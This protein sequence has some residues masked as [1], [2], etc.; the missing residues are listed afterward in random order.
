MTEFR[1][2][3][4]RKKLT[5]VSWV[6][7]MCLSTIGLC[8]NAI[9]IYIKFSMKP[10]NMPQ[11]F[12]NSLMYFVGPFFIVMTIICGYFTYRMIYKRKNSAIVEFIVG[13]N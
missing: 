8:A 11:E 13:K 6:A 4:F 12:Y 7:M 3:R 1:D 2:L 10:E 5:Y 9:L